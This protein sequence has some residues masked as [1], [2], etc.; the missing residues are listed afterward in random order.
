M[1]SWRKSR[2]QKCQIFPP[3][4]KLWLAFNHKPIIADDSEG[5]WRRVHLI[6]F[7]RQFKPEEQDKDLLR[8]LRAEAPGILAWAVI[9]C[10]EWQRVGLGM[11]PAV[12]EATAAY[13][14][15]SDHLGQFI[16]DC[17]VVAPVASVPSGTL[18]QHYQAWAKVNEEVLLSRNTFGE[19]LERRGVTRGRTGRE[20]TR[21]WVG[22][23]LRADTP[24]PADASSDNSPTRE[25]VIGKKTESLSASVSVSA[26]HQKS[27][28]K[29][30]SG[31][32]APQ[33]ERSGG[34]EKRV[35]EVEI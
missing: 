15:E 25:V 34:A 2:R 12:A 22:V 17:C 32:T 23:G 27:A 5:M 10:L 1:K 33:A 19:R 13:R 4:H 31:S 21:I 18:W 7:N 8:K 3:T 28:L 14:E 16:E 24:T 26:T 6:P 30:A 20:G 35:L 29:G 11:P 9:G